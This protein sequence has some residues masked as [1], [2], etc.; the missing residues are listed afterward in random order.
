MS[1]VSVLECVPSRVW[2]LVKIV[3]MEGPLSRA[4]LQ[5][6]MMPSGGD[7]QVF[8]NLV[9]ETVRLGLL[10]EQD[11][12]RLAGV[13]KP[14]EVES[15]EWFVNFVEHA[16]MTATPESGNSN[17]RYALSWLLTCNPGIDIGWNDDQKPRMQEELAGQ[18]FD[19]TNSS[20]FAM[21]AYWARFLGY[22]IGFEMGRKVIVPD[23]TE[24]IGR[25]LDVVFEGEIEISS[26]QFFARLALA[27]PVLEYGSV[28]SE[29]EVNLKRKRPDNQISAATSIALLQLEARGDVALVHKADADVHLLDVMFG[30]PKQVSHLKAAKPMKK[31][32]FK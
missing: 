10:D 16:I 21:L 12:V 6:R 15:I 25:R 30:D 23:P 19:I 5:A 26:C 9:R 20:R 31:G 29:V 17:V 2:S 4:E 13:T 18:D 8:G 3:A 32:R 28:R 27:L 1:L 24:A 11:D 14:Y 7:Q 22:A